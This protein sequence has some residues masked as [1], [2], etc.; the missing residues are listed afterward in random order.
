MIA[1]KLI[2]VRFTGCVL[3]DGSC[4]ESWDLTQSIRPEYG[5]L[6][7]TF[8]PA[9]SFYSL[10]FAYWLFFL[11]FVFQDSCTPSSYLIPTHT[12]QQLWHVWAQKVAARVTYSNVLSTI[13]RG[14][15][16]FNRNVFQSIC[17]PD[18]ANSLVKSSWQLNV[19]WYSSPCTNH[20]TITISHWIQKNTFLE[21]G[22]DNLKVFCVE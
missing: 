17:L 7:A 19:S 22:F 1:S 6:K 10:A 8:K 15:W 11:Y 4:W 12:V 13:R 21:S 3:L 5:Q 2:S 16:V 20:Q 14:K 9:I 18:N